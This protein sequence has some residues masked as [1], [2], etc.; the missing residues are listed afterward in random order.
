MKLVH[1]I[2]RTAGGGGRTIGLNCIAPCAREFATVA[3]TGRA[4]DLAEL[5]EQAGVRTQRLSLDAPAR[6][7]F[8]VLRMAR[9]LRRERPDVVVLHGQP[10]G[11]TGGL[12]VRWAGV[13]AVVYFPWFPSFYTDW[14]TLRVV[15][16]HWVERVSCGV[17][18]KV[19]CAGGATRYQY[20]LRGLATEEQLVMV[21]AGIAVG[22]E[23]ATRPR[24]ATALPDR[25]AA[26]ARVGWD[27]K[28][29]RVVCVGRLADQKRVDWLVRAWRWVEERNAEARLA[30]V[31][32]G[33]ERGKLEALARELGLRRCEFLGYR[34]AGAEFFGAA[35]VAV[36]TSLF[37]APGFTVL[38][39][40][41]AGC[42]VVA[43][44]V[45]GVAEAVRESGGGRLVP[46]G[47]PV[48][49][50]G[51]IGE[52]LGNAGLRAELGAAGRGFVARRHSL[53]AV[54][55]RQFALYREV[56]ARGG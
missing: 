32:D 41:A 39:A 22:A 21:P 5:L 56:G 34:A 44:E 27:R 29:P 30:I 16:N 15:R 9:I 37:E 1:V 33:A 17:A 40:L 38:E 25:A 8:S 50:A 23:D 51:A 4:G 54:L 42:P 36:V 45:D 35:D 7:V 28:C 49:L 12:A 43:T 3:L 13:R 55:Q 24:T 2:G 10:A 20:L 14:D 31:G 53:E 46:P 11:F 26:R 18:R 47:D 6:S 48:A 19:V 52:L